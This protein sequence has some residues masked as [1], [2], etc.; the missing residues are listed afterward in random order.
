MYHTND[1]EFQ[2]KV[3]AYVEQ[4]LSEKKAERKAAHRLL[5]QDT[6]TLAE[7]YQYLV[8]AMYGLR[9]SS[10]HHM[11][12]T[13]IQN[14]TEEG[15]TFRKALKKAIRKNRTSFRE[16]VQRQES[17]TSSGSEDESLETDE[18]TDTSQADSDGEEETP[19]KLP[20]QGY[21]RSDF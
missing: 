1:D 12:L 2:A 20:P 19:N 8:S 17:Y 16:I 13:D 14:Y 9:F 10:F 18:A 11:I 15:F 4:G 6:K 3:N 7:K 5:D 21:L